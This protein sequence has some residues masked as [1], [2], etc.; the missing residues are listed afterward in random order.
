ME[1]YLIPTLEGWKA[2]L[3]WSVDPSDTSSTKWSHVNDRSGIDHG[4]SAG[5]RLASLEMSQ[6]H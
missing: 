3:A 6:I 1:Y 2:E 4:K 5:Q